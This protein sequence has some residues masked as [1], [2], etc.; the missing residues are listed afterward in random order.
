MKVKC[1][2]CGIMCF[3]GCKDEEKEMAQHM[4]RKHGIEKW[5]IT[6]DKFQSWEGDIDYDVNY[7][8]ELIILLEPN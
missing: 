8:D 4:E 6:K 2:I 5:R 1:P 7:D 3:D